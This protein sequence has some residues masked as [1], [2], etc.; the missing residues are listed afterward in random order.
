MSSNVFSGGSTKESKNTS[1]EVKCQCIRCKRAIQKRNGTISPDDI[2]YNFQE[3][4]FVNLPIDN[5][6]LDIL[7]TDARKL[8]QEG[9]EMINKGYFLKVKGYKLLNFAERTHPGDNAVTSDRSE[10]IC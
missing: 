10:C 7:V 3:I 4:P 6:F 5:E 8:I 9:D 1:Q 2:S